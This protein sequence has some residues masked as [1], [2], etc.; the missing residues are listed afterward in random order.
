[1]HSA[2]LILFSQF[3]FRYFLIFNRN[4]EIA[5][6]H[7]ATSYISVIFSILPTSEKKMPSMK[8]ASSLHF[9]LNSF[10]QS[11]TPSD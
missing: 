1:M 7:F 5:L 4:I 11:D 3:L 10:F 9:I 8:I 6:V 2:I